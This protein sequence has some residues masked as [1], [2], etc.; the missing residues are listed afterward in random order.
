MAACGEVFVPGSPIDSMI[1]KAKIAMTTR[2]SGG[3]YHIDKK[4]NTTKLFDAKTGRS[5]NLRRRYTEGYNNVDLEGYIVFDYDFASDKVIKKLEEYLQYIK[6]ME[7]INLDVNDINLNELTLND[8]IE[9]EEKNSMPFIPR[10]VINSINSTL[11]GL[12][13]F[14]SKREAKK[15]I[16]DD[17][18]EI[19][20]KTD[21]G[22]EYSYESDKE[23]EDET[24]AKLKSEEVEEDCEAGT[25]FKTEEGEASNLESDESDDE[26]SREPFFGIKGT[27]RSFNLNMAESILHLFLKRRGV[28]SSEAAA[29]N[30]H[31]QF[32]YAKTFIKDADEEVKRVLSQ[33]MEALKEELQDVDYNKVDW[34]VNAYKILCWSSWAPSIK[35]KV[36]SATTTIYDALL[37]RF[38]SKDKGQWKDVFTDTPSAAKGAKNAYDSKKGYNKDDRKAARS[39]HDDRL[40]K[41]TTE[42]DFW[43]FDVC[44]EAYRDST[45][46]FLSKAEGLGFE[47][48]FKYLHMVALIYKKNGVVS[49]IIVHDPLCDIF[50]S[51]ANSWISWK[52]VQRQ[53]GKALTATYSKPLL[54]SYSP[55]TV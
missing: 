6:N 52:E 15:D 4:G 13:N 32:G 45:S 25:A 22:F 55:R 41:M 7:E 17:M 31:L 53:A 34:L 14:G 19:V 39:V 42:S 33:F 26:E 40:N 50:R 48:F 9:L 18:F 12:N 36:S 28:P 24:G 29:Q 1:N 11:D 51:S 43:I 23:E 3:I 8:V 46:S 35:H 21:E 30:E 10:L 38:K 54:P 27:L 44:S 20:T 5:T 47:P 2:K 49:V 16:R 37:C